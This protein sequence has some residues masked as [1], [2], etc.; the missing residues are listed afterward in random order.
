MSCSS[1]HPGE[2]GYLPLATTY[3]VAYAMRDPVIGSE[4]TF[5]LNFSHFHEPFDAVLANLLRDALAREA[6]DVEPGPFRYL[7]SSRK[8]LWRY[9]VKNGTSGCCPIKH[10]SSPSLG[11]R[12]TW[13]GEYERR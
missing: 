9:P 4:F 10:G 12:G 1:N 13:L 3:I 7:V 5:S 11:Q 6:E 8:G 2:R